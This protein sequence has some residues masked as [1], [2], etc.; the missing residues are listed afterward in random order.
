M[1]ICIGIFFEL[2][3]I[4]F[5]S[6]SAAV[7]NSIFFNLISLAI[8]VFNGSTYFGNKSSNILLLLFYLYIFIHVLILIMI[9]IMLMMILFFQNM[10]L[11]HY[12]YNI[13]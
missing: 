6:S 4:S 10:N 7:S 11:N 8:F 13:S 2:F 5:L 12:N 3:P 1:S 9:L